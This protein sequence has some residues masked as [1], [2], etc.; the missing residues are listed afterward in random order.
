[1]QIAAAFS[2]ILV[3]CSSP[4][5]MTPSESSPGVRTTEPADSISPKTNIKGDPR[6]SGSSL[7]DAGA[8][9]SSALYDASQVVDATE[10]VV[11]DSSPAPPRNE[12]RRVP[13]TCAC[14][15]LAT[16]V[17]YCEGYFTPPSDFPVDQTNIRIQESGDAGLSFWAP[18]NSYVTGMTPGSP[19]LPGP[20]TAC[21]LWCPL[22]S[23][24]SAVIT[25]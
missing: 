25:Y 2:L 1:M 22:P 4:S 16:R 15:Y 21:L 9:E 10:T 11:Q 19:C 24:L 6:D 13:V 5:F 20:N 3:A 7:V 18:D 12:G 17:R 8:M 14:R 23:M